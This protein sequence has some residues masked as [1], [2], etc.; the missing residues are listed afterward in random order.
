MI[1]EKDEVVGGLEWRLRHGLVA[2]PISNSE[3][4]R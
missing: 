4:K 2:T 1:G 3:E